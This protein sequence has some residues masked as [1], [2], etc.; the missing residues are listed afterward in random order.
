MSLQFW[1]DQQGAYDIYDVYVPHN[2]Q[3]TA[4]RYF[5]ELY[6]DGY[7]SRF[8]LMWGNNDTISLQGK[9]RERIV[10]SDFD[11]S[12]FLGEGHQTLEL[13]ADTA[14]RV[15]TALD[16][17]R[18]MDPGKVAKA[19][20][21]SPARVRDIM[22]KNPSGRKLSLAESAS[23]AG[24]A[25]LELQ[26][27]WLPLLSDAQGAAQA[28]AQQLNEP[29]VQTYRVRRTVKETKCPVNANI[30]NYE[31]R[32]EVRGQ[33]IARISE[34]NVASLNG[35]LDPS[36]MAWELLPWSFVID[37]FIPIGNYLSAR[38]LAQ[39]VSGTFVT[40][41]TQREYFHTESGLPLNMWTERNT[42][43][44]YRHMRIFVNRTVSTS[45][46]TPK[47]SFKPLAK[48]ASWQHCANAVALLVSAPSSSQKLGRGW[49]RPDRKIRANMSW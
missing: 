7:S 16:G 21:V 26:Y 32:A 34:V 46:S 49:A 44:N 8:P 6:S 15:K 45:L 25:W 29:A 36:S 27:G 13:I 48:V 40:T 4:W 14:K 37:W 2:Y 31:Y 19:L 12:V 39:S 18:G 42:D 33:V 22:R 23:R 3:T 1:T 28:L 17:F 11:M 24:Q 30:K 35:L 43:F 47:P 41:V 20:G 10:G 5:R 9:L 38:G